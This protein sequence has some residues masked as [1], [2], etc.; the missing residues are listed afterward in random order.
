MHFDYHQR[1]IKCG[2]NDSQQVNGLSFV[3]SAA[4]APP[5]ST[6]IHRKR[7]RCNLGRHAFSVWTRNLAGFAQ[8]CG[9]QELIGDFVSHDKWVTLSHCP[10]KRAGSL[11]L[12]S[13]E[14]LELIGSL[15]S[16]PFGRQRQLGA[17]GRLRDAR[18]GLP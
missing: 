10:F 16:Y 11:N 2:R 18:L 8:C 9:F 15:R 17:N 7:R 5:R 13:G 14:G 1:E 6:S 12:R 4:R 3:Q